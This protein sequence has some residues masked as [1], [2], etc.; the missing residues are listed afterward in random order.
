MA[1]AVASRK[2]FALVEYFL[3]LLLLPLLLVSGFFLRFFLYI[4]FSFS[5]FF[6]VG[7]VNK[8]KF[9]CE[10][11]QRVHFFRIQSE[12]LLHLLLLLLCRD[13]L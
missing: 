1:V 3:L 4:T 12:A 2:S 7:N 9:E 10:L 5:F 6:G 11:M 8:N 13:S